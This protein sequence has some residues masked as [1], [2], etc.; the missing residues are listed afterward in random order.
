MG[1]LMPNGV[2]HEYEQ[3]EPREPANEAEHL[4]EMAWGI[5]ANAGQGDWTREG[6]QWKEAAERWRDQ[7]H[8]YLSLTQT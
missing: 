5:I 1:N 8:R 2:A 3:D 4:L 7:Y 6:W